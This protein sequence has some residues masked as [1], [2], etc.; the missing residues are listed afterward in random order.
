MEFIHFSRAT[1]NDP[2]LILHCDYPIRNQLYSLELSDFSKDDQRVNKI[3]VPVLPE[4]NVVGSSKGLLCLCDSSAKN[5]VYVY[6]PFSRD[7]I[8]LPK[9]T[10][11][12]HQYPVFGFG[13]DQT[14]NKYKV[15]KA[16]YRASRYGPRNLNCRFVSFQA[17]VQI[18]TLG[19][20]AWRN[21]GRLPYRLIHQGPSQVLVCERIHWRTASRGF[22]SS[23]S[24]ISFDFEDEQFREVPKPECGGLDNRPNFHLVDLGGYLSATVYYND[25][26]FEIWIMRE[27]GVKESWIKEF[28]IGNHVPRTLVE[29]DSNSAQP[30]KDSKLY[31]KSSFVRALGLL[32]TGEVLLE[33]KCRAL[34]TYNKKDGAFKHLTFPGLPNWFEGVLLEGSLNWID[35]LVND[36]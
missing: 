13:F 7:Y 34:V 17:E 16:V 5:I 35:T 3:R 24:I 30:F 1:E 33:Y 22:R 10:E 25:D 8:E 12:L 20:P 9:S 11:L 15:M 27:Y 29:V 4:F 21:F 26:R 14:I 23:S 18:L 6:N 36:T 2:C 32:K 31:R 28:N 19:I